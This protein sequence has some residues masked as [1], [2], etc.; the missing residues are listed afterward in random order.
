MR[1]RAWWSRLRGTLRRDDGLEREME[2]EIAFHLEMSTRRNVER[3]MTPQAAAREARLAFGSLEAAREDARQAHRAR[4]AENIVADVRFG[5]RALRRTPSFATAAILTMALGIGASTAIFSVVDGVLL[6]PLPVP[7]PE[8]FAYLGWVWSKGNDVPSLTA[9]QY[10]F[11]RERA[12]SLAAVA[13]YQT[14][15]AQLGTAAAAAPVRGLRVN[16]DFFRALGFEP[17]LGRAFVAAELQTGTSPVVILGDS[18]WRTRFGADADIVG[19]SILLDGESRTVVGVMPAAFAFPPAVEHVGYLVPLAVHANPADEGHNTEVIARLRHGTTTAVRDADLRALS[20]AFQT[21]YP[22]LA[23]AKESF[24]IYTHR[25]V[26]A[27]SLRRTLWLLFGAVSLLLLIACANTATLLLVRASARQREIGVRVSIGA[28]PGRILQQL[29]TEGVLLSVLST[30]LGV[31]VGALLLRGFLA[32]A[33]AALPAG[34]TPALDGRAVVY[35][36]MISGLTGLV[37]G[38]AAAIPSLRLRASSRLLSGARGVTAGGARTREALVFLETASAMV[39]LAGAT[40][41]MA[42]F[43]RLVNVDPGFDADRVIA[44]RLGRLPAR[45]DA[46]RREQLVD[47]LLERIRRVPGVEHAA[48]APNLPLER[49]LNFPVDT[50]EH[51]ELAVGATELRF[52]SPGYFAALGVPL[53]GRD[54]DGTDREGS[55]PVAIV[56]QTFARRFWG[57]ESPIG[58]TIQIGHFKDRWLSPQLAHQTRVIALAGDVREIGLDRPPRPTVILPRA[59]R[60]DDRGPVFLVR[61]SGSGLAGTVRSELLAEEP[62]L[63]PTLEPLAAVI[64]RSVAGPRFRTWMIATFAGAALLLAAIGIYGVIAGLVEQRQ[65][66][67]GIRLSLGA[68]GTAMAL[69]VLRRCMM[70]VA[71]GAAAGLLTFW[72]VRSSLAS[73]LYGTSASDPRILAAAAATLALVAAFAAWVPARRAAQVDPAITLRLE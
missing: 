59:Q 16:G 65:R 20:Q 36:V 63:V 47:R 34:L 43:V 37:F 3:G 46:G 27:G 32:L 70:L 38:L 39:L 61:G 31:G 68:T 18:V 10:Q 22:D 51:P 40:L 29:L 33:P 42:S 7:Q 69:H 35:A 54:F 49:G 60:A 23:S 25:E 64:S 9:F 45:Y 15:E 21:A 44:V 57:R 73:M 71:A 41:L 5:A 48:A 11:V 58:R 4:L 24:K 12:Q 30:T 26:F 62:Q 52:V 28:A 53:T 56:N 14:Q 1:L 17:R 13:A 50:R 72:A 19:R 66:E 2:R 67:I 55:E 6:R 8:D